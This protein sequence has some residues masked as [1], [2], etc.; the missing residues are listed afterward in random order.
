LC[1]AAAVDF[2]ILDRPR[3]ALPSAGDL[4]TFRVKVQAI[5]VREPKDFAG[6]F[7]TIKQLQ[8]RARLVR[9]SPGKGGLTAT[10]MAASIPEPRSFDGTEI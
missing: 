9:R 1:A 3:E 2:A 4:P 5:G 8:R 10:L 7:S 6:A